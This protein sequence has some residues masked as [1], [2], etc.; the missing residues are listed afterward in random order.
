MKKISIVV[1]VILAIIIGINIIGL[2]NGS[3]EKLSLKINPQNQIELK[4]LLAYVP[5]NTLFLFGNKNSIPKEYLDARI[6]NINSILNGFQKIIQDENIS[7]DL[8]RDINFIFN[9]HREFLKNYKNNSLEKMGFN[10]INDKGVIYE[11]KNALI[12][13]ST[14]KDSKNFID[15]INSIAKESNLSIDWKKCRGF[16]CISTDSNESDI[17]FTLIV[18]SK[19]VVFS[20]YRKEIR[21]EILKHLIEKPNI[22]NSYS[23]DKFNNFLKENGFLGYGDGFINI[24]RVA[25]YLVQKSNIDKNCSKIILDITKR[26]NRLNIGKSKL[27]KKESNTLIILN[28]DK[29]LTNS[30]KEIANKEILIQRAKRPIFDFG[31]NINAQGL[32]N[33]I[34]TFSNYIAE[35]NNRYG[36]S[37]INA[38]ELKQGAFIAS[39]SIEM[40]LEQISQIY[41]SLNELDIDKK[42]KGVSRV[43][44]ILQIASPNP[45]SLINMIKIISPELASLNIPTDGTEINITKFLDKLLPPSAPE[46]KISIK[47]KII[48]LRVGEKVNMQKAN[49]KTNT[50]FWSKVNY[51]K[52]YKL[53]L[54]AMKEGENRDMNISLENISQENRAE[55]ER[56]LKE[57]Q[58]DR[59]KTKELMDI[60]YD[61][62]STSSTAIYFD[63]RG[64]VLE[65]NKRED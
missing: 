47:G 13:R 19:S 27:S 22:K 60:L 62:N 34:V 31:F 18:K 11:Y 16:E 48:T 40:A 25:N 39:M 23:I 56:A 49:L 46:I 45:T 7:N 43:S 44:A 9:Y 26:A 64:V 10:G 5:Q 6:K 37:K 54:I 52:Y 59:E 17:I 42:N 28:L 12:A 4:E 65:I 8:S 35:I 1:A 53:L 29:N 32:S 41:F 36:C 21:D 15:S 55:F 57:I 2:K 63:N 24:K 38:N 14:I 30:I 51:K 50:I 3:L 58:K 33:T 61:S 20:L